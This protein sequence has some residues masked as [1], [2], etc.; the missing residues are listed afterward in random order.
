MTLL[1]HGGIGRQMAQIPQLRTGSRSGNSVSGWISQALTLA[2]VALACGLSACAGYTGAASVGQHQD[3]QTA[4]LTAGSSS[5]AFGNVPMGTTSALTV[6]IT[7]T[8][9]AAA[10]ISQ[11]TIA[12]TGFSVLGNP[13]SGSIGV[14][15]GVMVQIQFAPQASGAAS[16]SFTLASDASN[17]PMSITLSGTGTAPGLSVSPTSLSFGTINVGANSS[18]TLTLTNLGTATVTISGVTPSGTGITV[19]GIS[20]PS[21]LAAGANTTFSV[22]FAPAAAGPMSGNISVANDSPV[23]PLNIPISGTGGQAEIGANPSSIN[24]GS[25]TDGNTNSQPIQ[26]SNTGNSVLTISQI[27]VIG[28]ASGFSETGL[29]TPVTIQ[30]GNQVSF[31][32]VFDP[33]GTGA[34]TGSISLVNNA[35]NSPLTISLAGTGAS[36]TRT[37]S[38]SAPSVAFGNVND[39]TTANQNVTLT[40]T[41]NANVTISNV[42]STGAGFGESGV[43]SGLTLTP[44]QTATLN[45]SFDPSSAGGV[46]GSVTVASDAAN[47]PLSIS[48]SG[49][50]VAGGSQSSIA[51]AWTA[52]TSSSVAGYNVYRGTIP[53]SYALISSSPVSGTSYVDDTVQSGQNI[54]YYYVVTAVDNSGIQSGDSNQAAATVP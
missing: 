51:L 43:Q 7:N 44:N 21:T 5:L 31:N 41:G 45:I 54:T 23:S 47:S 35:P 29:S 3:P 49:T 14:G 53:G 50:G 28:G 16:G 8:G 4:V 12:G 1:T 39:G 52:S 38:A 42:T 9:T 19:G 48:L 18:K 10:N 26:V 24:F 37:L 27:T 15:Q 25:V 2:V 22:E 46:S 30:P 32:A 13:P 6:T 17:S 33:S 11:A 20:V 40:N 34:V 36:V